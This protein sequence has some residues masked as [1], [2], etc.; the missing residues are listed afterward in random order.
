MMSPG[1]I[2]VPDPQQIDNK[3]AYAEITIDAPIE[4]VWA[5]LI[6][7]NAYDTWNPFTYKVEIDQVAVG[8]VLSFSVRMSKRYIRRQLEIIKVI[9]AP[10][11]LVWTPPP[12]KPGQPVRH[13]LLTELRDGR[14]RYQTWESFSGILGIIVRLFFL[15]A[16]QRGFTDMANALKVHVEGQKKSP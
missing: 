2:S 5:T 1:S 13:Q 6:D 12:G 11:L 9:D 4:A 7:L 3:T 8:Q 10:H 16:V 14:T 15:K